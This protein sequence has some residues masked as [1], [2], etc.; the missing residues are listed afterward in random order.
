M[1][2][3]A[4]LGWSVVTAQTARRRPPLSSLTGIQ[5]PP[6]RT[7]AARGCRRRSAN[8]TRSRA[9]P[10]ATT[11]PT[12]LPPDPLPRGVVARAPRTGRD[13]ER[14]PLPQPDDPGKHAHPADRGDEG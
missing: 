7:P 5:R 2:V 14:H 12:P 8:R 3:A 10:P 1:A 6:A 13:R 9:P 4:A 11:G